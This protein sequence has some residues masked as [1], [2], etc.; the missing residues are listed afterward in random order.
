MTWSSTA[1][2]DILN[3]CKEITPSVLVLPPQAQFHLF[4]HIIVTASL[5]NF[6][7]QRLFRPIFHVLSL[8]E[9]IR[10]VLVFRDCWLWLY[11]HL[12]CL[13]GLC[14]RHFHLSHLGWC[15]S[16][17][18]G[19]MGLFIALNGLVDIRLV[20]LHCIQLFAIYWLRTCLHLVKFDD[21]RLILGLFMLLNWRIVDLLIAVLLLKLLHFLV[22]H[23]MGVFNNAVCVYFRF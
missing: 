13:V 10:W 12:V 2:I 23:E 11:R 18:L 4:G 21:C 6:F 20:I 14:S 1:A 22:A 8:G 9:V 19:I 16:F 17:Q 7:L 15:R 3:F 5:P